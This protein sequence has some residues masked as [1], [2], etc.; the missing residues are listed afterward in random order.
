MFTFD[1]S[2][3]FADPKDH[4]AVNY[5]LWRFIGT[6]ILI[7]SVRGDWLNCKSSETSSRYLEIFPPTS[8][9]KKRPIIHKLDCE[10]VKNE[11]ESV[12]GCLRLPDNIMW[13]RSGLMMTEASLLDWA[14]QK[15]C[16]GNQIIEDEVL[17][18]IR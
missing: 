13:N 16:R 8:S 1:F 4:G 9:L 6:E 7:K 15:N 18:Y 11:H 14:T 3:P 5:N 12:S 2:S 10:I 17:S